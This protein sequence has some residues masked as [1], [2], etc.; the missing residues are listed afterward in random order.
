MTV[1]RRFLVA[2]AALALLAS[3]A[4][5]QNAVAFQPVVG[6]IPNGPTLGVT[7]AVSIDRRYVR[8]G[9]NPQFIAVEGFNTQQVPGAVG[10]GPGGPGALGGVGLRAVGGEQFM[11][12]MDGVISPA[13]GFGYPDTPSGYGFAGNQAPANVASPDIAAMQ[14]RAQV[15]REAATRAA[16]SKTLRR[17]K[18]SRAKH[19]ASAAASG[20]QSKRS[21]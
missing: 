10:G 11:A 21:P 12:G 19:P 20:A 5:A 18:S 17:G 9:I 3:S 14:A 6:V 7:P 2:G 15:N 8:L 1:I 13:M 16:V 4:R